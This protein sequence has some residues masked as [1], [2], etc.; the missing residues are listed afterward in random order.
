MQSLQAPYVSHDTFV[1]PD[2]RQPG[3]PNEDAILRAYGAGVGV[4]EDRWKLNLQAQL[5][6]SVLF[7]LAGICLLWTIVLLFSRWLPAWLVTFGLTVALTAL[8][9]ALFAGVSRSPSRAQAQSASGRDA[10]APAADPSAIEEL[11]ATELESE[12]SPVFVPNSGEGAASG[13]PGAGTGR[14][15][16]HP[17]V[18]AGTFES[19]SDAHASEPD[20]EMDDAKTRPLSAPPPPPPVRKPMRAEMASGVSFNG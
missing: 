19:D 17:I 1:R 18:A 12:R 10:Q 20:A 6:G 5:V 2:Q 9:L 11:D 14:L 15:T 3:L 8:G 7:V 4:P 16:P 13:F